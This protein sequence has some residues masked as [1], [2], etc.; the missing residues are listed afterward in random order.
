MFLTSGQSLGGGENKKKKNEIACH[1][2]K[3]S[4]NNVL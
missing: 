1:G 2:F 4:M 3:I